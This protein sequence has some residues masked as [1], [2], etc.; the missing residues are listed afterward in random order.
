MIKACWE[1]E[2]LCA[3]QKPLVLMAREVEERTA[4]GDT[5]CWTLKVS[6]GLDFILRGLGS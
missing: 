4:G 3:I 5:L 6:S 1:E 2:E